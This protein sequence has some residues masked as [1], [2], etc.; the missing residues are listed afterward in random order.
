MSAEYIRSKVAT[1]F[2]Q[3]YSATEIFYENHAID[4]ERTEGYTQVT[5]RLASKQQITFGDDPVMRR[6]GAVQ[7]DIY[8]RAGLGSKES[9]ETLD[10]AEALFT[11]KS[12]DGIEFGDVQT[13][14]PQPVAGWHRLTLRCPFY[15]DEI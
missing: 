2:S 1:Y 11:R 14:P 10:V 8:V 15:Y 4:T 12:L 13:L 5:L 9:Y 6:R 7:I 3:N